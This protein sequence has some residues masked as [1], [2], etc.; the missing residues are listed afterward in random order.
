MAY[1]GVNGK[2]EIVYSGAEGVGGIGKATGSQRVID[3]H[4][5]GMGTWQVMNVGVAGDEMPAANGRTNGIM[6]IG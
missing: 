6:I 2:G 3:G 5:V 1:F 4:W